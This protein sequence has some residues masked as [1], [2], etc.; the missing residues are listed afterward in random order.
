MEAYLKETFTPVFLHS[1][2]EQTRIRLRIMAPYGSA[3]VTLVCM[4]A[5]WISP[6]TVTLAV[7]LA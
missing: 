3:L 7:D 2:R 1:S 6:Q 5:Q 4:I